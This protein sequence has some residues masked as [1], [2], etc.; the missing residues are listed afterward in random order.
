MDS[1]PYRMWVSYLLLLLSQQDVHPQKILDVCCGTG[2]VCELLDDEGF[3]M[4]GFDLSLPMV[5][6]A[7]EKARHSLKKIRYEAMDAA[8]FE[9]GDT[10]DAAFS[11]FDSLNYITDPDRLNCAIV[12]VAKHLQPGGSFIFDLNTAYAFEAKLFDQKSKG[13]KARVKYD[14]VGDYDPKSRIIKVDMK[15]WW[16]GAAYHELHEQRAHTDAEIRSILT[17]AGFTEIRIY[18]SYTLDPPREKSDR[19]HYAAIRE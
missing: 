1:V 12:Q 5:L 13:A 7:R 2:S 14:W 9:L 6:R 17:G 10:F 8:S 15:F 19:V 18:D 3:Q 16:N 11:F 4:T